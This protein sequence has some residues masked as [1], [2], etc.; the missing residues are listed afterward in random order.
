M[1]WASWLSFP[2][3]QLPV[4]GKHRWA[5]EAN[6]KKLPLVSV[7]VPFDFCS[8]YCSTYCIGFCSAYSSAFSV[9]VLSSGSTFTFRKLRKRVLVVV[10]WYFRSGAAQRLQ[11]PSTVLSLQWR[12]YTQTHTHTAWTLHPN[13]T[14]CSSLSV[15]T[16]STSQPNQ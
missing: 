4:T 14:N 2:W 9:R 1:N 16:Q 12:V 15:R 5:G 6:S 10:F 11:L 3:D 13:T 7:R 8:A